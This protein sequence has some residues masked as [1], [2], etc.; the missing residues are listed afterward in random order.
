MAHLGLAHRGIAP[1]HSLALSHFDS[2]LMRRDLV[3]ADPSTWLMEFDGLLVDVRHAAVAPGRW[4]RCWYMCGPMAASAWRTPG[5]CMSAPASWNG[6]RGMHR[7][8]GVIE[9]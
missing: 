4:Y 3:Q 1:S 2:Q 7:P 8:R 6:G 5:A 9:R